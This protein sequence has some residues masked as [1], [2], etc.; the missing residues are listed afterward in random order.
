M[1]WASRS[2]VGGGGRGQATGTIVPMHSSSNALSFCAWRD[3][4]GPPTGPPASLC[5]E[6]DAELKTSVS[7]LEMR[8]FKKKPPSAS[9]ALSQ[10]LCQALCTLCVTCPHPATVPLPSA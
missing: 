8:P 7:V 2:Q 4:E 10:A 1:F 9:L 6:Q 5:P 3:L